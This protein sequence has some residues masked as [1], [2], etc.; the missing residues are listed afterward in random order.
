MTKKIRITWTKSAIGYAKD[1][2]ATVRALGLKRL[3]HTVEQDDSPAVRGMVLK[4][5]HLI[6]V[7]EVQ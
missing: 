2:K 3:N 4:V 6:N 7:E 1:Q 5:R